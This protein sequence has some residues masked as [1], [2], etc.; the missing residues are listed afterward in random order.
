MIPMHLTR[1]FFLSLAALLPLG[2]LSCNKEEI[3]DYKVPVPEAVDIGMVLTRTD[4]TTY[5]LLWADANIGVSKEYDYGNYYKWGE[6]YPKGDKKNKKDFT[7]HTSVLPAGRDVAH[8]LLGGKWRMPTIEEFKALIDL[9]KTNPDYT[10]EQYTE[11]LNEYGIVMTNGLRIT[12]KSTGKSI[13]FPAA[14]FKHGRE[15]EGESYY[16]YYW[17]SSGADDN[18]WLF[19][20]HDVAIEYFPNERD[21]GLPIRAV[22]EE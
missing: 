16:G 3:P 6:L 13:F 9:G 1:S 20:F 11:Y 2:L 18:A 4:G 15:V 12:Q 7:K 17:S 10:L 21:M 5:K 8:A 22:C 19:R 14:G